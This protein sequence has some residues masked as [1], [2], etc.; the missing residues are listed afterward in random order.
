MK[1]NNMKKRQGENKKN[2]EIM[3]SSCQSEPVRIDDYDSYILISFRIYD[4][5]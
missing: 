5:T 3:K 2:Y 1:S 4:N